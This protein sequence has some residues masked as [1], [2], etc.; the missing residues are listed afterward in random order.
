MSQAIKFVRGGAAF[1]STFF[2]RI[3]YP[4]NQ[5]NPEQIVNQAMN[6]LHPEWVKRGLIKKAN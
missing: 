6:K 4:A 1:I 2:Y 5:T 3:F